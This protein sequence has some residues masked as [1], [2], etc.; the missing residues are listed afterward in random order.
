MKRFITDRLPFVEAKCRGKD[1]LDIGCVNHTLNVTERPDWLHG[2]IAAV[3]KSVLGLD[4]EK[5]A[6]EELNRRG[7]NM[8]VGDAETFDLR[9]RRP[10][11]F[12]VIVAGEIIEHLTN[13][14]AFLE[15]LRRH[16]APGGIIVL[17]TPNAYG[18]MY[19][20]EVLLLGQ[21]TLNDDH[22]MTF[23]RKQLYRFLE[24]CGFGVAEFHY[25]NEIGRNR[26]EWWAKYFYQPLWWLQCLVSFVRP[27]F[28]KG[29]ACVILP[30]N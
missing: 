12:E 10:G 26:H 19:F 3:A 16:L 30:R 28:S 23:S 5:E 21:E 8:V 7:Y 14:G 18:F 22:T 11:G 27:A 6:V 17:T 4:N 13:P 15:N 24:K 2:R 1:V 20:L 29:L 9:D 25:V